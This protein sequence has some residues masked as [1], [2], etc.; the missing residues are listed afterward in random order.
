MLHHPHGFVSPLCLSL[1]YSATFDNF[2]PGNY[3][4]LMHRDLLPYPDI[5]L[6]CGSRV[7][8]SL[9]SHP[10]PSRDGACDWFFH[11]QLRQLTYL[12]KFPPVE[13]SLR[14]HMATS[15]FIVDVSICVVE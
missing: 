13:V 6:R 10:L 2:A 9:P 12:G 4:L 8:Q 3:L 1:Q 14:G 5:L 15:F 7:G 11:R